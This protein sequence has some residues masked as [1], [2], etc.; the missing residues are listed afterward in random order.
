MVGARALGVVRWLW[1]VCAACAL[2]AILV[3]SAMAAGADEPEVGAAVLIKKTVTGILGTSERQ[4]ETGFRVHRNELIRT[5]PEAQAEL[6]LDDN[7]KL[8]L[9]PETEL[10]LDE[11]AVGSGGSA[12]SIGLKFLKGTLRFLTGKNAS[13]SY[14]IETPAATIGV[15]GTI[16]DVYVAPSGDTFVLILKGKVEICSEKRT[17]RYHRTI[18][19]VV[20]VTGLGVVSQPMKWTANLARGVG[21][22]QAF[23]FVVQKLVIDPVP[24]HNHRAISDDVKALEQGGRTIERTLRKVNPF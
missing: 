19:R 17:C 18:G 5:G 11:Y 8:A 16:F 4:L 1:A 2:T 6:K 23:P 13:D 3:T 14:K 24:R 7:T 12:P 20:Q 15:R 9:G 21:V 10:R 22:A